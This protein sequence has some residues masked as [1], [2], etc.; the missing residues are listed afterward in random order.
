[1]QVTSF[2]PEVSVVTPTYNRREFI[3]ILIKIYANQTFPKEK[4]EWIIID[5][6]Q[7]KVEDLFLEASTWIPNIRYINIDE[8]LRIGAKRNYMNKEAR[9][10]IIIAMDDDDYYSPT[11]VQTIVDAFH[12]YP[13]ANVVGS[14]EMYLYYTDT[15]KIYT[16]GPYQQNHATN[17]TM[18]WRKS[19]SDTHNHDEFVTKAEEASFLD[20]YTH[21]MIQL[22]SRTILHI[23]H[24]DNTVDKQRLRKV[25]LS[26]P[27][28]AKEKMRL[29]KYKLSDLVK[30]DDIFSFYD[31]FL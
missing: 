21:P 16:V 26:D 1:M 29:C 18:A 6:G 20:N 19:Y 27:R 8:K 24:K 3:P 25:H 2:M 30:E 17:N 31:T 15:K 13:K 14:S 28:Q 9:A 4:M 5:D 10:P 22:H 23:C 12:Q 11:R 7:D